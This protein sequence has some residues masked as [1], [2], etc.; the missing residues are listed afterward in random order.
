MD[1]KTLGYVVGVAAIAVAAYAVYE[2]GDIGY[3]ECTAK[4]CKVAVLADDACSDDK[5]KADPPKLKVKTKGAD[6]YWTAPNGYQFCADDGPKIKDPEVEKLYGSQFINRCKVASIP[7]SC[8][9]TMPV[10]AQHYHWT[11]VGDIVK[12]FEYEITMTK[13]AANN[14]AGGPKCKIDPYIKNG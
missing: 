12:K 11:S 5:K 8:V 7:G 4:E 9:S 1:N 3:V 14:I 2:W 13:T 6:I 10:C